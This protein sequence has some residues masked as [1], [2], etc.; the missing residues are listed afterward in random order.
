ME[1]DGGCRDIAIKHIAAHR[2]QLEGLAIVPFLPD[3]NYGCEEYGSVVAQLP[4]LNV[5]RLRHKHF[6]QGEV[7]DK[8]LYCWE[9]LSSSDISL[10]TEPVRQSLSLK[11]IVR[12][13]DD[14][15]VKLLGMSYNEWEDTE[16]FCS[17][18]F[19]CLHVPPGTLSRKA[20]VTTSQ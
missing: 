19:A 14:R 5:F 13:A 15:A 12:N 16:L 8:D 7:T 3:T 6:K 18:S 1:R 4:R 11:C 10:L 20:I 17:F 9:R 2:Q